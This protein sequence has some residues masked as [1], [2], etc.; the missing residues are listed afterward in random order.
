MQKK[1][2]CGVDKVDAALLTASMGM[3]VGG[4]SLLSTII[5]APVVLGL[6]IG[7]LVCGLLGVG[8]KFISYRLAVKAKNT[9]RLQFWP[10]AR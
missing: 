9:T 6:E 8:G 4:V 2:R 3:G 7:A 1:Y 10:R 5:A